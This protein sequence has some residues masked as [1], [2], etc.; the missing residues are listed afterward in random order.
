[1]V[2][3]IFAILFESAHW[4]RLR[5]DFDEASL[6]RAWHLT[7]LLMAG[8]MV[9]I[10]MDGNRVMLVPRLL[11][12]SPVVLVPMQFVQMFGLREK[13]PL[14]TFSF[15]AR[16]R[17]ERNRKL[18]LTG[19][20][21]QINFAQV[22]VVIAMLAS[23][24]G[25]EAKRSKE[26]FLIGLVLLTAWA[27]LGL[28]H[29]RRIAVLVCLLLACGMSIGGML[30]LRGLYDLATEGRWR[31]EDTHK[32]QSNYLTS[33]G[34]IGE[35]KQSPEIIWR[36][37]TLQG[38]TPT[39]LQ[40]AV[41]NDYNAGRWSYQGPSPDEDFKDLVTVEPVDGDSYYLTA[42][43]ASDE[44]INTST[45]YEAAISPDLPRIAI[46]GAASAHTALPVPTSVTS[47]RKFEFDG[48]DRNVMGTVRI[49]PKEAVINGEILWNGQPSADFP[50]V[51]ESSGRSEW[52]KT[53]KSAKSR[54]DLSVNADELMAVRTMVDELGLR[55]LPL[56]GKLAAIRALFSTK[57]QYSRYLS[58]A[59]LTPDTNGAR[60]A[61]SQFLLRARSGH[62]EYFATAA[63]LML[64]EVGVP[65]RYVIGFAVME[66]DPKHRESVIR[67]IHGHAWCRVWDEAANGWIDFDP[68]P[69]GW[70]AADTPR[71]LWYQGFVDW[72]LRAREDFFIWRNEPGNRLL[73]S[74]ILVV[75]GLIGAGVIGRSLW[76]SRRRL[77][78]GSRPSSGH[79]IQTP[80]HELEPLAR[81]LLGQRSAGTTL[82]G[83][84]AG[85]KPHLPDPPLLDRAIGAYSHLRF[86]P[87]AEQEGM[88]ELKE[89]VDEIVKVLRNIKRE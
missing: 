73:G 81:K 39:H 68:T 38:K 65:T 80:L 69:A 28:R 53:R 48:V 89:M 18:G 30:G 60:T 78:G 9:L 51:V 16:K 10:W 41:F 54:G 46:R 43:A 70:L 61:L 84:L 74:A 47:L 64:R 86:D 72:M 7:V 85:L 14:N 3:G 11:E 52:R 31:E 26:A 55:G 5:W 22:Y 45:H 66:H 71:P 58:I 25:V 50:P 35:L 12:W 42:R 88:G 32:G 33:I 29:G 57:F 77:D 62:C 23:T 76:K 4:T 13:M 44:E 17:W 83:W 34:R 63:A 37:K 6:I 36:I 59:R 49:Y 20:R 21:S 87:I 27:I 19:D 1:M 56:N 2:G 82:G 75:I 8:A 67:G 24:L 15:F 79:E 40:T